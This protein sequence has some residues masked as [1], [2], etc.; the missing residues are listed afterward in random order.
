MLRV[1]MPALVALANVTAAEESAPFPNL[2]V[3]QLDSRSW[4]VEGGLPSA[5]VFDLLQAQDGYLWI[6]TN[7]GVA[8]FDGVK[9]SVFDQRNTPALGSNQVRR[10]GESRD[11]TVWAGMKGGGLTA[12]RSGRHRRAEAIDVLDGQTVSAIFEDRDGVLWIGTDSGMWRA[13][14][15][16]FARVQGAPETVLAIA[17]DLEGKLW[18]G[19]SSGLVV[20]E[21]S[22]LVAPGFD[23]SGTD[24]VTPEVKLLVAARDGTL[25]IGTHGHG[26][27]QVGGEVRRNILPNGRINVLYEDRSGEI[28]YAGTGG[29]LKRASSGGR[30]NASWLKQGVNCMTQDREGGLWLGSVGSPSGLRLL[31]APHEAA[32]RPDGSIERPLETITR[33]NFW[34]LSASAQSDST[35]VNDAAAGIFWNQDPDSVFHQ[36]NA[37]RLAPRYRCL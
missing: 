33:R 3:D 26:L 21:G 31:K 16:E 4:G 27:F 22:E 6:A 29:K 19:G 2:P 32:F 17:E 30:K 20:R 34:A 28:W 7:E 36:S 13:E 1:L 15:R 18:L 10:L 14:G 11:G 12:F 25:W 23:F 8:R 35:G 5:D 9:F 24:G 37:D